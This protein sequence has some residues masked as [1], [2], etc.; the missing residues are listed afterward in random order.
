MAKQYTVHVEQQIRRSRSAVWT[1]SAGPNTQ[2]TLPKEAILEPGGT[3]L[4]YASAEIGEIEFSTPVAA[5]VILPEQLQQEVETLLP[6]I[7]DNPLPL[8]SLY[9]RYGLYEEALELVGKLM[10]AN[11]ED[12]VVIEIRSK[13]RSLLYL[14]D[15]P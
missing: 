8:I 11:P 7:K 2:I 3:Y 15:R 9:E 13:L 5:F 6:S 10:N 14:P 4:W 1:G 12:S